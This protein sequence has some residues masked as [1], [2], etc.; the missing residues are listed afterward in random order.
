[1]NDCYYAKRD[2]RE[3]KQEV[4]RTLMDRHHT[5]SYQKLSAPINA[6]NT[7]PSLDDINRLYNIEFSASNV[8]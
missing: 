6:F 1:M 3:C 8:D 5:G 2:W 7:Q 4:R